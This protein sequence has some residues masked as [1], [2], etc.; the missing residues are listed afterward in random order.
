MH[1]RGNTE[2]YLEI[3]V[4]GSRTNTFQKQV[5][6]RLCIYQLPSNFTFISKPFLTIPKTPS[7]DYF[8]L[9]TN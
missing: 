4:S 3:S 1:K 7:H 2:S 5:F 9:C 6:I 8:N